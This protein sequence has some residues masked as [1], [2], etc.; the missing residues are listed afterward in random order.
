MNALTQVRLIW[1]AG[2]IQGGIV[3]VNGILPGRLRVREKMEDVP[4]FLKQ[5]FYVHWI[6]LVLIVGWFSALCFGFAGE[7][8]GGSALGRFL[9]GFIAVFW[10]LR[11]A[12]QCFYY[13]RAVRRANRQLDA[14]YLASLVALSLIFGWAALHLAT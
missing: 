5:I 4:T 12:L 6:Y 7:L 13:D 11:V 2:A 3:L 14:V 9:S 8:S 1:V 10:L